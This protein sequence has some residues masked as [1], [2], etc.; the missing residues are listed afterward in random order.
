MVVLVDGALTLYVERGGSTLLTW[1]DDLRPRS[2]RPPQALADAARRGALGRLTVEKADGEQLLG[3]GPRRCARPSTPPGSSPPRAGS[4]CAPR[5]TEADVPEGDAVWRTARRLHHALAGPP[6]DAHRLP[7]PGARHRRPVRRHRH[8]D[9]RRAAST[10]SPARRTTARPGPCTPTSRWRARGA[11]TRRGE[12][13]GRPGHQAASC[14]TPSERVAVGFQL[15]IVELVPRE[16]EDQRRR[17]PRPRPARPRLGRARGRPPLRADP[18]RPLGEALLDQRN[19][20]GIGTIYRTELC[21]LTGYDPRSPGQRGRPTRY[22]W[23]ALRS[24]CSIQNRHLPRSPRPA[25]SAAGGACGSTASD[26]ERCP[27]CGTP[28]AYDELGEPAASAGVL[29]PVVPT[30]R[31]DAAGQAAE[32]T[33]SARLR[34][35]DRLRRGQQRSGL[36]DGHGVGDLTQHVGQRHLEGVAQRVRAAR[37]RLPSGRARSRRC[38]PG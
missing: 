2:S 27:R 25:T 32:A 3:S 16:H 9:A 6:L 1:T 22:G 12:R 14:S 17:P 8:R 10:C 26:S 31:D 11:S 19:L 5:G 13:W 30:D 36:L 33:T 21:F 38:S 35:A 4:G 29:V 7:R 15:G 34:R 18:D 23:S 24:S 20:A 28:I 37:R